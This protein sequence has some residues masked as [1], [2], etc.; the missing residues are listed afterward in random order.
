[1]IAMSTNIPVGLKVTFL[2]HGIISGLVGIQHVLFPKVWTDLAGMEISET[3]TWRLIGAALVAFSISSFLA[4]REV[5]WEK[6]R[7]LIIMESVWSFFGGL[8]IIWGILYEGLAMLEWLN[9]IVLAYFA[10]VFTYFLVK[11]RWN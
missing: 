8:V 7:I 3:V 2:L 4:Y 1:M 9:V 6:V 10:F 11:M 5:I